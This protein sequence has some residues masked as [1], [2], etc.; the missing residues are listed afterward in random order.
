MDPSTINPFVFDTIQN[1]YISHLSQL[2]GLMGHYAVQLF[3]VLATLEIAFFGLIW[4]LK[5]QENMGHFL[6]KIIKLGM[7]FYLISNYSSL[8]SILVNGLTAISLHSIDSD[9]AKVIFSPD[10]L[11]KYGFDSAISL[12]SLAVQYGS[13]NVGITA[14]YLTLGF[15]ILT[16]FALIACQII[17]LITSFYI[18]ALLSLLFLPFGAFGITENFLATSIQSL[19]KAA[20]KIFAVILIVGIGISIWATFNPTSYSNTTTL[21]QPLGLFFATLIITIL[22]WKVPPIVAEVVGQIGG[23]LFHSNSSSETASAPTVNISTATTMT[24]SLAAATTVQGAAGL[25]SVSSAG[26]MP[27]ASP[28]GA[29]SVIVSGGAAGSNLSGLSKELSE[30]NKAVKM[31]TEGISK[32]TLSKLK[33]TFKE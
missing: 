29:A 11:W 17:V 22:T 9:A 2:F 23:S 21:D 5:Q 18:L 8:I 25:S 33:S 24:S 15:G 27:N 7:I 30:L 3:Y 4:A 1:T 28:S 31:Q 14:I 13:T 19:L 12:L 20:V 16:L 6:F 26:Q 32:A 10:L